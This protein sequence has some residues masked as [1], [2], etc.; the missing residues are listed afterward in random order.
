[1]FVV[2]CNA[3]KVPVSPVTGEVIYNGKP[4][5]N[6]LISFVPQ[7]QNNRGAS[8]QSEHDGSFVL[9]TQGATKNGAMTGEYKI[10]VS[11]VVEIDDSGNEVKR[12]ITSTFDPNAA[13]EEPMHPQ[14]NLLPEKYSKEETTDLT[15]TVE[16]KKNHFKLTLKD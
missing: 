4:V 11:K 16:K 14:K 15:A 2:G 10:V 3:D 9:L 13:P 5:E 7:S 8:G 1:M 6:A 12:K